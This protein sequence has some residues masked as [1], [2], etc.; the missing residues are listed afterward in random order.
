MKAW[1]SETLQENPDP[2]LRR[3][4]ARE[5]RRQAP[6][7]TERIGCVVEFQH[8][9][10]ARIG[11]FHGPGRHGRAWVVGSDGKRRQVEERRLLHLARQ[12]LPL[13]DLDEARRALRRID[14]RR[15]EAQ[16]GIDL[17]PLWELTLEEPE[18][19]WK[20]DDLA[21]VYFAGP[22][23]AEP[24]GK[25]DGEEPAVLA[26]ALAD[27]RYFAMREGRFRA[28]PAETVRRRLAL[29][30]ERRVAAARL[31]G[32]AAWLRSVA[33]GEN[34]PEPPGAEEAVSLLEK[35]VLADGEAVPEA[36]VELMR[37]AHLHGAAVAFET[38]VR[39]GHWHA[40]E[41]L[42][43]HRAG[44]SAVFPPQTCEAARAVRV[45]VPARRWWGRQVWG[46]AVEGEA[47]QQVFSLRRVW[48][49]Y[50]LGIHSCAAS[51][52]ADADAALEAEAAARGTALRLPEGRIGILPP[53]LEEKAAFRAGERQWALSLVLRLGAGFEVRD[54]RMRLSRVRPRA[55]LAQD[56]IPPVE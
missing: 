23:E 16:Q 32:Q 8:G 21:E 1:Y 43:L 3:M 55:I 25:A 51:L 29:E 53:V 30:A 36:A 19:W 5:L 40:D 42:D 49:G 34:A 48:G 4:I 20:I 9:R 17:H 18:R 31:E 15:R 56:V 2:E 12:K 11:V 24:V 39:L 13:A 7:P 26:R 47:C 10:E 22:A 44:I 50:R 52:W 45:A 28:L 38:L 54:A 35:A 33:D 41:N 46:W 37:R 14:R 6:D 27:G